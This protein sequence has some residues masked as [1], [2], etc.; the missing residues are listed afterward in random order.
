MKPTWILVSL[1]LLAGCA[2]HRSSQP[3]Q[4]AST[5]PPLVAANAVTAPTPPLLTPPPAATLIDALP[6]DIEAAVHTYVESGKA[7]LI[8]QTKA[9]FVRFPYGLSQPEVRCRPD[10]ICDIELEPG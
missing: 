7:P 2:A 9:G 6:P 8:D 5:I 1:C 3:S 4:E 10:A